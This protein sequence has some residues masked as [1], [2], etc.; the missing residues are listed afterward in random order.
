MRTRKPLVAVI[1]EFFVDH[2]F[3]DF[4]FL[5][6][7]GEECF[8]RRY[9]RE[10]GGGAAITACGLA[11]LGI[12]VLAVGSIGRED[13]QWVLQRLNSFGVD[14][15]NLHVEPDE[16]TGVTVSVSTRE[17]RPFFSYY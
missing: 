4:N 5:P 17:D 12:D 15:S 9:A 14:C 11:K 10:V 1:G 7:L 3:S 6:R 13:G 16:T 8:A 2:I